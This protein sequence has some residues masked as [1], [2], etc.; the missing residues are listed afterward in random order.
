MHDML[1]QVTLSLVLLASLTVPK[2]RSSVGKLQQHDNGSVTSQSK[3]K[4]Q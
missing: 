2:E 1:N 3:T 4:M